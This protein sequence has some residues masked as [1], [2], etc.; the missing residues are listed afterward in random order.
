MVKQCNPWIL[1]A[2]RCNHDLKFIVVSNKDNKYLIYYIIDY[3]AKTSIYTMHMYSLLQI[4]VKKKP[5]LLKI[6]I[7]MTEL[8]KVDVW[9][10]KVWTQLEV[11]NKY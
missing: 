9:S 6:Q 5:Q 7:R 2:S 1:L 10:I 3:I 11:N 4:V 8:I